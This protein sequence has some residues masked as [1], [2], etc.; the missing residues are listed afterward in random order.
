MATTAFTS[1]LPEVLPQVPGCAEIVAV[2]A[3]RNAAIEFCDNTLFWQASQDP[4]TVANTDFPLLLTGVAGAR[5]TQ[6]LTC[7]VDGTPIDPTTMDAL[8]NSV[9]FWRTKVAS[10]PSNYFLPDPYNLSLYP[11]LDTGV[12]VEL[13]LR[14]AY[15]PTRVATGI[16]EYVYQKHLEVIAAGALNKLMVQPAQPWSNPEL[17]AFYREKF[18]KGITDASIDASKSFGRAVKAVSSRAFA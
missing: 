17:A 13:V 5:V 2:N 9:P 11:M 8:E 3:V 6:V 14:V 15:T 10:S 1:F 7:V 12:S 16:E 18:M 4:V